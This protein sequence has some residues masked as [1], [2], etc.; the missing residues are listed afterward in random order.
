MSD[1]EYDYIV[2]GAGSA[3]CVLANRL[4][5]REG[6]TVLLLEAGA[7]DDKREISIPAAFSELFQSDYDWE[8]YTEPQSELNDR[9][10][11]WPRGKTLGGTSAINAMVFC[12]GH[13]S[14]YDQWHESGADGW[15]WD[16]IQPVYKR[17]ETHYRGDSS[18][19][20][21]DGP[22]TVSELRAPNE[23]SRAFVDAGV[24]LGYSRNTDF[25]DGTTEGFGLF[26]VTQEN[27]ARQSVADAYLKPVMDRSN[28]IVET[29]AMVTRVRVE[30]DRAVGIEYDQNGTTHVVDAR[31]E[32]ILSAGAIDSPHLLML[33]G[34]G[35]ANHLSE[36]GIEVVADVPAVGQNLQDHPLVGVNYELTEP[37]GLDDADSL[38]NVLKYMLL[39]RGPLTS[40]V[41]EA[42][43]FLQSDDAATTPDIGLVFAPA[44]FVRHGF[45]EFDTTGFGIAACL[46]RPKS[47]GEI[48][49]QS[50]DPLDDPVI[51]PNYL[52]HPDDVE[53][54]VEGVR[55]AR[56]VGEADPFDE[57]REREVLPGKDAESDA[58]LVDHIREYTQTFYH[59]AGTCQ[60]GT[61]DGAVVNERL[62]VTN[63]AD[64][65]VVDASV[66]PRV[67]GAPTNAAT[68]MIAE[69]AAELILPD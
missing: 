5:A 30:N 14:E 27:G 57:Y 36:H 54:L 6:S 29:E 56:Q 53:R 43:A 22:I 1:D 58:E 60:M 2:V 19:H 38:W 47:R 17:L 69:R 46:Y 7:P 37:V 4:S 39:K 64:L 24:S 15:T 51:D 13:P 32:V 67:I 18:E 63:V 41:A 50:S 49:L 45:E 26:D 34:I 9:R 62:Q 44:F 20:G 25:N 31:N 48:R 8:Y 61:G 65:R 55:I 35:P 10:L 68:I 11:Y 3:G 12:R 21:T 16:T 52:D 59:P 66:M 40:N 33:S 23:L 42:G 28:L